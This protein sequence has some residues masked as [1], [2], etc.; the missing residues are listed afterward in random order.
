RHAVHAVRRAV[1]LRAGCANPRGGSSRARRARRAA[2][3]IGGGIMKVRSTSVALGLVLTATSA[4]AQ[5]GRQVG[6]NSVRLNLRPADRQ[7]TPIA[8]TADSLPLTLD[9]AVRRAV[10]HNPEL[11]VVRLGTEV[12][13][14]HVGEAR[15]AYTPVF[16]TLFGRSSANA[17]PANFLLGTSGVDTRDLFS[18]TGVRQRVPWGNGTWSVS[19]DAART[20]SNNLLNSFDPTLQSGFQLAFSQPL[21]KDRT[22]DAARQQFI[23]AKTNEQSSELLFRES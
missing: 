4:F 23:I 20:T 7:P 21:L 17:A 16:S 2:A 1:D 12:E 6:L 5:S 13:A 9:E 8:M 18:S 3:G 11:T 10:E 19:W 15:T 22:I 14:A